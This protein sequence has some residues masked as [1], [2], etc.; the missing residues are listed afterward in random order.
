MMASNFFHYGGIKIIT[1]KSNKLF[2]PPK[3]LSF[4]S[5]I[6]PFFLWFQTG[7]PLWTLDPGPLFGKIL[8]FFLFESGR[9]HFDISHF[10]APLSSKWWTADCWCT[11]S[12]KY[13]SPLKKRWLIFKFW[14]KLYS[15]TM[16]CHTVNLRDQT[17]GSKIL[18]LFKVW[19]K[20]IWSVLY[21]TTCNR[22]RTKGE[23]SCE[24]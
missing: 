23:W 14:K 18:H 3:L 21:L 24:M 2:Y 10:T 8:R 11:W 4:L 15:S 13:S 5:L 22:E 1:R 7:W 6:L 16:K 19:K 20:I 9:R 12:I 17:I